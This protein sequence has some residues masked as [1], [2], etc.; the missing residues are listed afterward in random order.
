[1][2]SDERNRVANTVLAAIRGCVSKPRL[3]ELNLHLD[4]LLVLF[5]DQATAFQTAGYQQGKDDADRQ[6]YSRGVAD[7]MIAVDCRQ[8]CRDLTD[9]QPPPELK[10]LQ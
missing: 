8:D 6:A 2:T 7:G 5:G 4:A 1:V 3:T 10:R 9:I